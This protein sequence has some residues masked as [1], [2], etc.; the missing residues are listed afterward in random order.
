[1]VSITAF[2]TVGVWNPLPVR[3]SRLVRNWCGGM[4]S[5]TAFSTVGAW[6]MV[7]AGTVI[8]LGGHLEESPGY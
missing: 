3:R 8:R 1:M 6:R 7:R 2:S 5:I 4:V